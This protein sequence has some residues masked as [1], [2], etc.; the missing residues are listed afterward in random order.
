MGEQGFG[1]I[2]VIGAGSWGTAVAGLVAP[3]CEEAVLWAHSQVVVDGIN[4]YH[5]NPR[6]L[7]GYEL[8]ENVSATGRIPEAARDADAV[9]LVV[10]SK[11][12]R[13]IAGRLSG[14][15]APEI[16]VL[17]LAKGIELDTGLL[18]TEVA[19]DEVGHPERVGALSGPNHAEEVCRG[20]LS[21][22]VLAA[23]DRALA[24]RM[25]QLFISRDFRVYV[26]SDVV[27]V[28]VCA[29]VKNVIAIACGAAS[30]LGAGDN[31]LAVIM[32]RGLAEISRVV[33]AKGGDPMTCMGLAGMGDLIA[34]CT[35]PH[36]RN[37]T[38]G[39]A[40]V[41]G[42]SL[43]QYERDTHMVV[44]GAQ[45]ARSVLAFAR[46]EGVEV[47]ITQAVHGMLYEGYSPDT[48]TSLLVDRLPHEEF[49]GLE[50]PAIGKALV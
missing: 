38:F 22:A 37:R 43:E 2:C 36:S 41:D 25:Q 31:T 21:A 49:Y 42:I 9:V 20:K 24:E 14:I 30:G 6:Y 48:A 33:S 39:Q 35:S 15:I 19:A 8:P 18:M 27:G 32:T 44:E 23:N 26:S 4:E 45:A 1:R 17:V 10:P 47:P 12:V 7:M 40:L 3:H 16:P 46:R 29:A 11:H 50:S 5:T 13:D 28:E 34:T